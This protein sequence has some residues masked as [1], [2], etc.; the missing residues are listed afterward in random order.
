MCPGQFHP[1]VGGAENQAKKL[2]LALIQKGHR[3]EVLTPQWERSWPKREAVGPLIIRR[4]PLIDLGRYARGV[5]GYGPLNTLL[6]AFQ[7]QRAVNRVAR[8]FDVIHVHVATALSYFVMEAGKRARKPVICKVAAGGDYFDLES[9]RRSLRLGSAPVRRMVERMDC[10][11]ATS[12]QIM[13]DL[14]ASGTDE[15]KIVKI[16]NG[17]EMH[18]RTRPIA[19]YARHFLYL[20]RLTSNPFRDFN[21]LLLAFDRL[22]RDVP[23]CELNLVGGGEREQEIRRLLGSL[24]HA[25]ERT[26][27]VG[28]S[29]AYPWLEWA[30]VLVQPSFGEGMSN[31]LLE[32]MAGGVACIANDIPPNREVLDEGRAGI[33]TPSGDVDALAEAMSRLATRWKA[34]ATLGALARHRAERVYA[35]ETVADQYVRLYER[36]SDR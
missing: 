2:S 27:L 26:R 18:H 12:N 32:G 34:A 21:A 9:F 33:L 3:V 29:P 5:R 35:I 10:W 8:R 24:T 14:I 16:P 36:L 7:V 22:A 15:K 4:F 25:R 11:I 13:G 28:F 1:I 30:D 17:V 20:G 31:A 6:R 23:G 19:S